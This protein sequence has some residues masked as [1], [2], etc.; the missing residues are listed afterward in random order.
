[1]RKAISSLVVV[2]LCS[3]LFF[4]QDIIADT[5]YD[6]PINN[7]I[8]TYMS[9]KAITNHRSPQWALQ[10]EAAND[11]NGLRV[12]NGR[13]LV[14]IGSGYNAP[15][16]TDIDVTLEN[17][18]VLPCTV[19]DMKGDQHTDPTNRWAISN[20]NVLEFIVDQGNLNSTARSRGDIGAIPGFEGQVTSINV[21]GATS[22]IVYD[23]TPITMPEKPVTK[24]T[25]PNVTIIID[26]NKTV[27]ET[28]SVAPT[29]EPKTPFEE[30]VDKLLDEARD[31]LNDV[32]Y[33]VPENISGN[34]QGI[35]DNINS[36]KDEKSEEDE[37]HEEPEVE[38]YIEPNVELTI[39]HDEPKI[40]PQITVSIDDEEEEFEVYYTTSS[41]ATTEIE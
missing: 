7:T 2:S 9:Y 4:T 38:E 18:V 10:T 34:L 13:Y 28:P 5:V 1:M 15:V 19:G 16:G 33:G 41:G 23:T 8:K 12:R 35:L 20:N 6:V 17:G 11:A 37:H 24:E 3:S 36:H 14:A 27:E 31:H 26:D 39:E 29:V 30:S 25:Q 40:E 32:T 22:E 21:L